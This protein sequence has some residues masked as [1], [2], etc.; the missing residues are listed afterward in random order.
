MAKKSFASFFQDSKVCMTE[1]AAHILKELYYFVGNNLTRITNLKRKER[2]KKTPTQERFVLR[3]SLGGD[4][5]FATIKSHRYRCQLTF[6]SVEGLKSWLHGSSM[7]FIVTSC[8]QC[9]CQYLQYFFGNYFL[10]S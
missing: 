2:K 4:C 6:S 5:L 10:R 1:W 8:K 9:S 7:R 3:K